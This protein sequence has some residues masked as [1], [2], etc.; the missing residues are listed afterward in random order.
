MTRTNGNR[1]IPVLVTGI[2]HVACSRASGWLDA[3]DPGQ[4][5]GAG[6]PRHDK[7]RRR[8]PFRRAGVLT[9]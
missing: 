1:V 5:A 4:F 2:R 3:G 6:K 8:W 9:Q 7:V